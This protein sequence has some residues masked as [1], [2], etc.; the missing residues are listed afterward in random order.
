MNARARVATSMALLFLAIGSTAWAEATRT[1][2]T[3]KGDTAT[4]TFD[5][6]DPET[7][8]LQNFAIAVAS[9][10]MQKQLPGGKAITVNTMLIVVQKDVCLDFLLFSAQGETTTQSFALASDLSSATLSTTVTVFDELTHQLYDFD[11]NLTW[12][13]QD[14]P[15]FENVKET[16]RDPELG[17]KI[18]S[19]VRGRHVAAEATGTL[20]GLGRNFALEP[21]VSAELQTENLGTLIIEKT[22]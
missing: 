7:P 17:L 10:L 13:A 4:A 5:S 3:V 8:C 9:D 18:M 12:I 15:V 11:V 16:F 22:T 14:T 6:I 21:S 2:L 20:V 1:L 19:H